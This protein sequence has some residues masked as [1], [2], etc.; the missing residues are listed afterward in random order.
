MVAE[1]K[2]SRC[3]LTSVLTLV[4]LA[5]WMT[6]VHAV[7]T[8]GTT[9]T[10]AAVAS[11][12]AGAAPFEGGITSDEYVIQVDDVLSIDGHQHVELTPLRPYT[13]AKDG[14]IKLTYIKRVKAAGMT[15]RKLED[16][17]EDRY[18]NFFKNLQ[19][20]IT[21]RSKT[22][23]VV[24]EVRNP[25]I[26]ALQKGTILT[27]IARA[28]GFTDYADRDDVIVMRATGPGLSERHRVDCQAI[29]KGKAE[30]FPIEPNDIIWV[31]RKG[32]L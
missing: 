6:S 20:S 31:D 3:F 12:G 22:Y 8:T 2:R 16:D 29:L 32:F 7:E 24:G 25:G 4:F 30:D 26:F 10:T 19:I 15:K 1:R 5:G 28:S 17:L 23:A 27:A 9:A 18:K 21:V 11:E 13:V 14:T